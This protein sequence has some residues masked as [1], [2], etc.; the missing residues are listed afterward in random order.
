MK[1]SSNPYVSFNKS[2]VEIPTEKVQTK[3]EQTIPDNYN[4]ADGWGKRT[5]MINDRVVISDDGAINNNIQRL[6]QVYGI[7]YDSLKEHIDDTIYE[8]IPQPPILPTQPPQKEK[9]K[10][11][12]FV[13]NWGALADFGGSTN[14]EKDIGAEW[15]RRSAH[16]WPAVYG[17]NPVYKFFT[18][19]NP[20]F[21]V[22]NPQSHIDPD[23]GLAIQPDVI[24][25]KID[26]QSVHKGKYLQLFNVD[27]TEARKAISV[28]ITNRAGTTSQTIFYEIVDS[29]DEG[30]VEGFGSSYQ[31]YYLYDPLIDDGKGK[32]VFQEDP[33]YNPRRVKFQVHFNDY[34]NGKNVRRNFNDRRP[35]IKIDGINFIENLQDENGNIITINDG[36]DIEKDKYDK[37][38]YFE[39]PPGPG[40]L[41]IYTDFNFSK[42]FKRKRRVWYKKE[43]FDI[44]LDSSLEGTVNLGTINIGKR[45]EKR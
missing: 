12:L 33:R 32:A 28:E 21:Y 14:A 37:V 44:D 35:D 17:I 8:L 29:D 40:T 11:A 2:K 20:L 26:G 18:G 38:F 9:Y 27:V 23:T 31:G 36:N 10:N 39:K 5:T 19:D 1:A 45:D 34:G 25:W 15:V 30:E 42:G 6:N 16:E 7:D 22:Y 43:E 13:A 4:Q 41:E 3:N 24:E